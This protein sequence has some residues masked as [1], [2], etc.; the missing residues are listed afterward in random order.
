[1]FVAHCLLAV[2]WEGLIDRHLGKCECYILD[3]REKKNKTQNKNTT[4]YFL[5]F[6][7]S[8]EKIAADYYEFIC[9]NTNSPAAEPDWLELSAKVFFSTDYDSLDLPNQ[10]KPWW[11]FC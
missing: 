6:I 8:D 5:F 3:V 4:K 11:H 9:T 2:R 7:F 10:F 1:M